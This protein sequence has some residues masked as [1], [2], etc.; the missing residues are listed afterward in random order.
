MKHTLAFF[1]AL[2]GSLWMNNVYSAY[3]AVGPANI[4]F[5][6]NGWYGEGFAIHLT[7]GIAGCGAPPTEFGI[8]ASHP[9]YKELVALLMSAYFTEKPI[10]VVVNTGNCTLGARTAI[11]SI[12]LR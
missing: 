12:R 5:I 7:Q 3:A 2:I 11:T 4:T 1:M 10:E 8:A 9:A 6:E